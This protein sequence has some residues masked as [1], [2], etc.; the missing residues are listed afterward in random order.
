MPVASWVDDYISWSI[1]GGLCCRTWIVDE[2]DHKIGDFCVPPHQG[3]PKDELKKC[4]RFVKSVS[5]RVSYDLLRSCLTDSQ[6][7]V[8][9]TRPPEWA[10]NKYMANFLYDTECGVDCALCGTGHYPNIVYDEENQEILASRFMTFHTILANQ[11]TFINALRESRRISGE[12][13]DAQ[14]IEYFLVS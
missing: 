1:S 11:S 10:F 7:I 12:I 4:K 9:G 6:L 13:E 14:N 8:N 2:G 3:G 5:C